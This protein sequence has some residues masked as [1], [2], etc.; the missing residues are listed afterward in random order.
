MLSA[1]M[2]YTLGQYAADIGLTYVIIP[3]ITLG[4]AAAAARRGA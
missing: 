4:M 1:P 3:T 2:N